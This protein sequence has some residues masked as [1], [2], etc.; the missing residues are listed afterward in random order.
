MNCG[1]LPENL[2]ESELFGHVRGAFTGAVRDKTGKF[3]YADGG[4]IFL[5]EVSTAS[6]A[7]QVKLLRVLQDRVIERVGGLATVPVDVRVLLATNQ[8]LA[9]AVRRGDFR[10]DL[11]YRINV[12]TITLPSLRERSQDIPTLAEYFLRRF[13]AEHN[14]PDI[15]LSRAALQRL[16]RYSWPG[17]VRELEN[18]IERA[19][20]LAPGSEIEP[21]DLPPAVAEGEE[22]LRAAPGPLSL[23]RALEDPERLILQ[24]ALEAH[25]WNRQRTA[26]ALQVNRTTLFNKMKKY[27]LLGRR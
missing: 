21:E 8:D 25:G 2:L 13:A 3:E 6:Q 23:K 5:D 15:R 4:T 26:A 14:R 27:G 19:V 7:L 24:Q 17:N 11:Y 12:V 9:E 10:E 16:L 22:E 1:A 18:A 20:I